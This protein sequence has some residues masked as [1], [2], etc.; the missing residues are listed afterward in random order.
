[1]KYRLYIDES[2]TH[3][4]CQ[5][6][7]IDK[8]Y[9]ALIG[10]I[11]EENEYIKNIQPK[12]RKIKQILSDDPDDLPILHREDIVLKKGCFSKLKNIDIHTEYNDLFFDLISNS[13]YCICVVVL[14]KTSHLNKYGNSAF[15]PYHYCLN[16]LLERYIL[17][18]TEKDGFGDVIAEARGKKEDGEL[19]Q[20]YSDFYQRGTYFLEAPLIQQRLTSS[21]IKIKRKDAG[22]EGI[23]FADLLALAS[24]L[25]TLHSL[26][27]MPVLTDNFCKIIIE[28]INGKYRK[29]SIGRINGFGRKLIK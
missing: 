6:D 8:R 27:E 21:K 7:K 10:L 24:K 20:A 28:K 25:D 29:S 13:D 5:S 18:L 9:L 2:G 17:F 26:G 23:E 19:R 15:H 14:D 4:Y 11:I 22:V 3:N 16:V 12:I 1:V